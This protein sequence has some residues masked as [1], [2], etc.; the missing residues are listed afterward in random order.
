MKKWKVRVE[1]NEK[2]H[3]ITIEATN[4]SDAYMQINTK[5][6]EGVIKSISEIRETEIKE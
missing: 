3:E 2:I 1:I 6:P 5:Y 4:Y